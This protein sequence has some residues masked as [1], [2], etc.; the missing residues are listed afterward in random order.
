MFMKY[1]YDLHIHSILSPDGD[2]LMTP[3]N[4]LNMAHIKKLDIIAVTDHNS[5]KQLPMIYDIAQSYDFLF[6]PGVEVHIKE[7]FHVLCYFKK[8]EDAMAFD[9]IIEEIQK[10]QNHK[11]SSDQ[12]QWITNIDD[13]PIDHYPYDL[14]MPL[15]LTLDELIK[16]IKPFEHLMVYAHVD[17]KRYS[18]LSYVEHTP[19]DA[20]ELNS[21]TDFAWIEDHH[22]E[23]HRIFYN[24]DAHIITDIAERGEKNMIELEELSIDALFKRVKHG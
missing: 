2:I 12:G 9:R 21:K 23:N 8:I 5:L 24:S 19:L 3:N 13:E 18:G 11:I 10:K 17:R 15:N 14:L 1:A 7:D 20:I 16:E 22:L 6:V 4:I